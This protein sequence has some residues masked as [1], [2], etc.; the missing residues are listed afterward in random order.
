M[1]VCQHF[2]ISVNNR[3]S[4][5]CYFPLCR[6][7]SPDNP[8]LALKLACETVFQVHPC[9]KRHV[10]SF[11][12]GSPGERECLRTNFCQPLRDFIGFVQQVI[13]L[14]RCYALVPMS[15]ASSA[16]TRLLDRIISSAL[17]APTTRRSVCVPPAAGIMPSA[18][19]GIA[20]CASSAAMRMSAQA[21]NLHARADN[22]AAHSRN[23]R[24]TK[25]KETAPRCRAPSVPAARLPVM[26]PCQTPSG[27]LQR[28]TH[29]HPRR[30]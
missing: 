27:R 10:H 5:P 15:L 4:S 8:T 14:A 25:W 3:P 17:L 6:R 18:T 22:I 7:L 26:A 11:K 19:S 16:P 29:A 20:N 30:L 21:G 28:R 24:L 1:S 2:C 13:G 12:N 23:Q 9:R